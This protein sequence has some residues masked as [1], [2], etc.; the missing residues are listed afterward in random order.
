MIKRD[1]FWEYV[2]LL[3]ESKVFESFGIFWVSLWVCDSF[4]CCFVK[5]VIKFMKLNKT[6]M[7]LICIESRIFSIIV[8]LFLLQFCKFLWVFD[9]F[10]RKLMVFLKGCS[11]FQRRRIIINVVF[12]E[13]KKWMQE[14]MIGSLEHKNHHIFYVIW[15]ILV[16]LL[17]EI[18]YKEINCFLLKLLTNLIW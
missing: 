8:F 6:R 3:F 12:D 1:S 13:N 11:K 14:N 17:I 15:I 7:M 16:V 2:R 4:C 10:L 5:F 18:V 9:D